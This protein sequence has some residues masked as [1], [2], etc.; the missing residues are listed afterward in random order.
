MATASD[1]RVSR[2]RTRL[3]QILERAI[4]DAVE[5]QIQDADAS[6]GSEAPKAEELNVEQM[7]DA[8]RCVFYPALEIMDAAI[9]RR[10]GANKRAGVLVEAEDAQLERRLADT[11][12][13]L[14]ELRSQVEHYRETLPRGVASVCHEQLERANDELERLLSSLKEPDRA[15]D[16][17]GPEYSSVTVSKSKHLMVSEQVERTIQLISNVNAEVAELE[18]KLKSVDRALDIVKVNDK[19]NAEIMP[20][21]KAAKLFRRFS[22]EDAQS[23]LEVGRV[24]N[25]TKENVLQ[26][27]PKAEGATRK[28]KTPDHQRHPEGA[29][30][31]SPGRVLRKR[32]LGKRPTNL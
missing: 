8:M 15:T 1:V 6:R 23:S 18:S 10:V 2:A 13:E 11:V 7:R 4:D 26:A 16:R 30:G 3:F 5:Q 21:R 32:L 12:S 17:N 31:P 22:Y 28:R 29:Q 20:H 27:R 19:E 14:T 9:E 24:P 25:E